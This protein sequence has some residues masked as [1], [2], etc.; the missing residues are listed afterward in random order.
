MTTAFLILI[1]LIAGFLFGK[2]HERIKWNALIRR[3]VLPNPTE[4][5]CQR[6]TR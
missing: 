1:N 3:R 4:A 2:L 5:Q 6:Y